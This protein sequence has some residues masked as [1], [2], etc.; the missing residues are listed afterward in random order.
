MPSSYAFFIKLLGLEGDITPLLRQVLE[1]KMDVKSA[2]KLV[3]LARERRYSV[4]FL[5]PCSY[6]RLCFAAFVA[7]HFKTTFTIDSRVGKEMTTDQ[8]SNSHLD[9]MMRELRKKYPRRIPVGCFS[10]HLT[11]LG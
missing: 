11:C 3:E 8:V 9:L 6:V 10:S 1:N 4:L 7:N 2:Q 5:P